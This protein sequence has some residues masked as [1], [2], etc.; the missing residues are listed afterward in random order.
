[1]ATPAPSPPASLAPPA[2]AGLLD[3][4]SDLLALLDDAGRIVWVNGGFVRASGHAAEA[5]HGRALV[6]LLQAQRTPPDDPSDPWQAVRDALGGDRPASVEALPWQHADGSLRAGALALTPLDASASAALPGVRWQAV[7]RDT[8]DRRAL[9]RREKHLAELLDTAQDFGRLGIWEREL[10]MG[11]GR[12]DRHMFRFFGLDPAAGVPDFDTVANRIHRDDR[13]GQRYRASTHA[14]GRYSSR[15]RIVVPG[16]PDRHV[17]SQWEVKAGPDGKPALVTGIMVDDTE[18]YN[19]AES[20]NKASAQL[21][22]AVDLGNIA[23]WRHD[24][25]SNRFFYNDRA[26][27]VVGI[28]PRPEGLAAE[29][30][31]A[32]I[33]PDDLPLVHATAEAALQSDRPTD[34]EARYRRSDGSW[35]YVLTRRMLRRD[36]HGEPLE[37]IG[38]A[39]DVSEQVEKNRQSSE[40]AKRLEI[41][42]AASGMGVWSRDPVTRRPEW[43]PQMFEI[44]G[45]P[46]AQGLPTRREWVEEIIHPDDRVRMRLAHDEMLASNGTTIE[47][48]YRIVRP[49]GAVRWLVNRS[50]HEV[51]DGRSTLFGITMDITNRVETETALRQANERIAL[52]AHGAGIGTW[53]CD[54]RSNRVQWDAQMFLLRGLDPEAGGDVDQLRVAL[55]HPEDL[56]RVQ[57]VNADSVREHRMATYEFRVRMPDGSW[58]WLASRSVPIY[59]ASGEAVRQIGVNWDIHERVMAEAERQDKL[60]AQRESEAKSQFLARMSHEL[61]TPLN[62]VLGFAQLLQLGGGLDGGQREKLDHIHSAGRHLLSLINDVLDLSSLEQGQLKVDLQPVPLADVLQEALPLVASLAERHGV[63][64]RLGPLPGVAFGDRTRIRQVVINLLTNGIKYNRRDGGQVAVDAEIQDGFVAL[65]VSDTGRGMTPQQ[66]GQL[67]EPFNR[68]GMEAE[69]IEGTGIGLAVVKALVERMGGTVAVASEPGHGTTFSVR[70]P[71]LAGTPVVLDAAPRTD[72]PADAPRRQGQLLYIEDNPVNQLLVEELVRSHAG[73]AIE[74][75]ATGAAGVQRA[76]VLRPGLVLVVIQLPGLDGFEV[77]RRLRAQPA[78]ADIPC[79]ALS[80]NA[81][82]EDIAR[83]LAA[84]FADYWTKPIAFSSFLAALDRLFPQHATTGAG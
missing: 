38:V 67:F 26:F 32:L 24:L 4:V 82:P 66:L 3:A 6:P 53:E 2:W 62:A 14:T 84:G 39:L 83:A 20:F 16:Q 19:L 29:E 77:V 63:T 34:M 73:L 45:R 43:N 44:V 65:T 41:A 70:L 17:H 15:Y 27:E 13:P 21:K 59:D 78:T 12:W 74:S 35:R 72:L 71:R 55:C 25:R 9:E 76:G 60:V 47:H 80:A 64:V 11:R 52:A 56:E 75:S 7:L 42:A 18:V 58:R 30:V 69:G 28:P 36:E 8:T 23:V 54:V 51:R 33:H 5:V 81:M 79:I 61:R 50:R 46:L 68:L 57:Q 49:D 37:F 31:R 22:M 40:M 48:Q 1:M 10:P